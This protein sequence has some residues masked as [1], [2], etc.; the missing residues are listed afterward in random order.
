MANC[1]TCGHAAHAC[2]CNMSYAARLRSL[3]LGVSAT[4][5]RSRVRYYDDEP[6]K[7]M[8]GGMDRR[9]RKARYMEDTAGLGA[10]YSD[11]KGGFVR[12]NEQEQR[13]E[14]VTDREIDKVYWNGPVVDET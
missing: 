11:G 4:P 8:F 1:S 13:L 9:E 5:S 3:T 14:R 12:R 10:A 2:V 7:D 6:L